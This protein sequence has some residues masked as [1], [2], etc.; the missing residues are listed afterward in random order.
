MREFVDAYAV[1]GVGPDAS[2][3]QLKTAHRALVRRHHPDLAASDPNVATRRM[4]EINV[5]YGLVRDPATRARYDALRG[6]RRRYARDAA[7]AAQWEELARAAGRWAGAWMGGERTR[8]RSYRVGR[9]LGRWL[10]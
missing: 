9:A 10:S 4:Q 8:T 1:L 5:A 2:A 6:K 7:L 3:E